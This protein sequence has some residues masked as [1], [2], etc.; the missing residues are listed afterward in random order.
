MFKLSFDHQENTSGLR[1]L[2]EILTT[3]CIHLFQVN[4]LTVLCMLPIIT[5]PPA[6]MAMH[7]S[8]RHCLTN[9]TEQTYW[10]AF[11]QYFWRSYGVFF[12]AVLIPVIAACASYFYA[13]YVL[14]QPIAFVMC[15][16]SIVVLI[17][18]TLAGAFLYPL[19]VSNK[20]SQA[21]RQSI[22]LGCGRLAR[23]IPAT[24]VSTVLTVIAI[25]FL[26]IT[27]P[28]FLLGGLVFPALLAQFFVRIYL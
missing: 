18:S 5:I 20:L 4:L 7:V 27:I 23:S 22:V 11:K 25:G 19:A 6:L 21:V 13:G 17:V 14:T 26:P 16:F 12:V 9:C 10:G 15:V 24:I 2:N 3:D 8:I 28:Y 1:R